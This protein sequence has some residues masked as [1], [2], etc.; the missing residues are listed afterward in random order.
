VSQNKPGKEAARGPINRYDL[1]GVAGAA[2]LVG[3]AAWVFPPSG[4][5]VGGLLALALAV[6]G[7][8]SAG[9]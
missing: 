7:A 9:K 1:L 5:I 6:L 2:A 8:R 3:G 4:L